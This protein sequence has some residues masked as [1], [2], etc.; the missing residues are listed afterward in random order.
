M[1]N[2]IAACSLLLMINSNA[3]ADDEVPDKFYIKQHL[4]SLTTSFDIVS[5]TKK[6]GTLYR[7]LFNIVPTYEFFDPN[8]N[9]TATARSKFFSITAHFDIYDKSDNF[10]GY[11]EEQ[12]LTF[13]PTFDIY[14]SDALTKLASAKM[15]I[16]G[17]TFYI[18]DPVTNQEM[19]TMHRPFLRIKNDWTIS[20]NKKDLFKS[21]HIDSRVL[22]TVLAFQGDIEIWR[23]NKP[24]DL[25]TFLNTSRTEL[26]PFK[27]KIAAASQEARLENVQKPDEKVL[28][29]LAIELENN[30][31]KNQ[32]NSNEEEQLSSFIDFSLKYME[33]NNLTDST[34][35]GIF[36]LLKMRLDGVV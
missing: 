3:F 1:K 7:R 12:F 21:K 30:Y 29:Q 27:A 15:N 17:T 6:I 14:G 26:E 25:S 19:A 9:K 31:K 23:A 22:M 35:K 10:L 8:D 18:Y 33:S 5:K 13:L 34:K 24:K 16:W 20:I 32:A 2:L 28:E 36:Y 4:I 11:A